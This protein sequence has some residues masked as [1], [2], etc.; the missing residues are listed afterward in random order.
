MRTSQVKI[1]VVVV[2]LL[3]LIVLVAVLSSCGGSHV[4]AVEAYRVALELVKNEYPDAYLAEIS[5]RANT[6][7]ELHELDVQGGCKDWSL[8]M[9]SPNQSKAISVHVHG[10]KAEVWF[11]TSKEAYPVSVVWSPI[12]DEKWIIDSSDAIQLAL[13][14]DGSQKY[15]RVQSL[16]LFWVTGSDRFLWDITILQSENLR[17]GLSYLVDAYTGE[18]IG[19]TYPTYD[20]IPVN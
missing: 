13:R 15:D 6:T 20:L 5:A 12:D 2:S 19:L 14:E 18:I 17:Q 1:V 10:S 9:Y 3:S 11:A 8:D 16:K 4:T 7:T